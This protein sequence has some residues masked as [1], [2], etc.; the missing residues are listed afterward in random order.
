MS[1][2][3]AVGEGGTVSAE[4]GFSTGPGAFFGHSVGASG[5]V[6]IGGSGSVN[7][8]GFGGSI[9]VTLGAK[10]VAVSSYTI[11]IGSPIPIS[12]ICF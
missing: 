4:V 12:T 8:N 10:G 7:G 9:G 5:G 11:A 2:A 1:T 6:G 3:M